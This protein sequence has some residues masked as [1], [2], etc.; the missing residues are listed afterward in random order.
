MLSKKLIGAWAFFDICLMAA[1]VLS[2]TLSIVWRQ[3][4]LLLNLT[5]SGVNLT[6]KCSMYFHV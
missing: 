4:N 6:S 3:P 1:G 5:F 2:L